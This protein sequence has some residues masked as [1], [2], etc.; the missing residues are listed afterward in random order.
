MSGSSSPLIFAIETLGTACAAAV[1]D[2]A[3]E[4]SRIVEEIGRGHAERV[5]DLCAETLQR[6]DVSWSELTHVAV[7]TGPGSFAGIRAGVA[8][9]RGFALSLGIPAVGVTA[10][11]ATA[12]GAEAA[13]EKFP[14]TVVLPAPKGLVFAQTFSAPNQAADDARLNDLSKFEIAAETVVGPVADLFVDRVERAVAITV[15]VGA[16]ARVAARRIRANDHQP[17]E[18]FYLRGPDA[19]APRPPLPRAERSNQAA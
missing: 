2:H 1:H 7:A 4:R 13:G 11:E 12:N 8:A 18:P 16:V 15:D 14:I 19:A 6:G 5:V 17:A 10:F 9:A 3:G